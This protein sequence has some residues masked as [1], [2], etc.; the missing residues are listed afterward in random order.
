MIKNQNA[1]IL[2]RILSEV[3]DIPKSQIGD[4]LSPKNCSS[5]DSFNNFALIAKIQDKFGVSF[6]LKEVQSISSVNKIKQLLSKHGI[7][8]LKKS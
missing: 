4:D 5:W 2:E 6:S 3:L 7:T 1:L 8:F